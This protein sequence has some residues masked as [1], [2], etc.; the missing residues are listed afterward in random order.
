MSPCSCGL[1][2]DVLRHK[3]IGRAD[4]LIYFNCTCGSTYTLTSK[5]L[6]DATVMRQEVIALDLTKDRPKPD[7]LKLNLFV[8]KYFRLWRHS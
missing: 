2:K 8:R 1:P 3:R 5:Q 7:I 4:G 6:L